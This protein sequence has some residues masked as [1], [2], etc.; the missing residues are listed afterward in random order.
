[1][2]KH[3]VMWKLKDEA[4]GSDKQTNAK[5]MKSKLEALRDLVPG[6]LALEVGLDLG[7]DKGA[8]DVVLYTEFEDENALNA[9]QA[10]PEHK[11]V[12]PFIGAVRDD[13]C[14]VDYRI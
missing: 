6:M 5:I 3:I 14:A 9:Y 2:I 1:M 8:Y 7:L 12:Y 4:E 13:R 10:H 11:A